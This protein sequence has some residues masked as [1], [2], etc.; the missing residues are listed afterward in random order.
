MV[1]TDAREVEVSRSYLPA[2]EAA[3]DDAERER[4]LGGLRSRR[5]HPG[6]FWVAKEDPRAADEAVTGQVPVEEVR[7]V[8]LLSNG[9]SRVVD[10]FGLTDWAGLMA[11]LAST[12]PDVVVARVHEAEQRHAVAQDD[13]TIACSTD[14][15]DP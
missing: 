8:A 14:L 4:V 1:V 7:A 11:D 9:A 10:T 13:A 15:A 5:N 2:L 3:R 12:G 6:G